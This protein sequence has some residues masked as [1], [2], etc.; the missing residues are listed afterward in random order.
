[1][2]SV[3]VL[4]LIIIV[5]HASS[6]LFH[7]ILNCIRTVVLTISRKISVALIVTYQIIH[8]AY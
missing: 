6:F 7:S 8:Q 3:Q 2:P 5:I 1:M 4:P